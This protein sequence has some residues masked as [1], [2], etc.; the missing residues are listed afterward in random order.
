MSSLHSTVPHLILVIGFS[1]LQQAKHLLF[2]GFH[3]LTA[4]F[5][6]FFILYILSTEILILILNYSA[7]SIVPDVF[8][9][10][11]LSIQIFK[12]IFRKHLFMHS[13]DSTH[14]IK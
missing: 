3:Q 5:H 9:C 10:S 11:C 13:F 6:I 2:Q 14:L 12:I 1:L 7:V 4:T 8:A